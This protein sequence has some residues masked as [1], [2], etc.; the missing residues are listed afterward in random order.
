MYIYFLAIPILRE[1]FP[2][3]T[4]INV[5]DVVSIGVGYFDVVNFKDI[6]RLPGIVMSYEVIKEV[7]EEIEHTNIEVQVGV[8]GGV[9]NWPYP[10]DQVYHEPDLKASWY[11]LESMDPLKI[12]TY[13][14]ITTAI[15]AA[16]F[17]D[18]L[19][20]LCKKAVSISG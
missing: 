11:G 20:E 12:D 7:I 13:P 19:I 8:H 2:G 15:A 6:K 10:V 3:T 1:H 5:G 17:N 18:Y 9:I 16:A 14:K 4:T